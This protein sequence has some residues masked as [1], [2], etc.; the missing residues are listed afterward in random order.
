MCY[1]VEL[2]NEDPMVH[3]I[4]CCRQNDKW[5]QRL[6]PA[7]GGTAQKKIIH[8]ANWS[9]LIHP[10]QRMTNAAGNLIETFEY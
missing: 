5:F 7:R 8:L 6:P 4:V 3:R 10:G 9:Q 1:V 2:L